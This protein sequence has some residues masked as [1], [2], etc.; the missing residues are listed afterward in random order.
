MGSSSGD[1]YGKH[2]PATCLHYSVLS[3]H[4]LQE[5]LNG[6]TPT[7]S[8]VKA[9][10]HEPYALCSG[11]EGGTLQ[12]A[13]PFKSLVTVQ[14]APEVGDP[15]RHNICQQSLECLLGVYCVE[16]TACAVR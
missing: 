11:D 2:G 6:V 4:G 9:L 14:A 3:C 8:S 1:R 7:V 16:P 15:H 10:H 13:V 12:T 5:C